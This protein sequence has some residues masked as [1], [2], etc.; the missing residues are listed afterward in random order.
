VRVGNRGKAGIGS[1]PIQRPHPSFA[2]ANA[3]FPPG[4]RLI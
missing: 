2:C 4:G 3:T 1:Y